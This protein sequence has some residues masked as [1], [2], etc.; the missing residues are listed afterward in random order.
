M[1]RGEDKVLLI[2][3]TEH[4]IKHLQK[5]VEMYASEAGGSMNAVGFSD[6]RHYLPLI[7]PR[8]ELVDAA[9]KLI[10]AIDDE[11][12]TVLHMFSNGA[13]F[14]FGEALRQRP[15][16]DPF[17]SVRRVIIDSAPGQFYMSDLPQGIS[18]MGTMVKMMP[19]GRCIWTCFGWL[20]ATIA[21]R[22]SSHRCR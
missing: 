18:F 15:S 17:P 9:A 7:R 4:A 11:Q 13:G 3:W 2:G 14:V 20:F 6:H 12:P 22:Q 19:G 16:A 5:Y 10:E 21:V 8:S 1:A